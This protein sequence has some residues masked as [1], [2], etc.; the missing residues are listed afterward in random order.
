MD[1]LQF[2]FTKDGCCQKALFVL[3]SVVD[4]FTTNDSNVYLAALDISRAYDFINHFEL[5]RQ[6]IRIWV[7]KSIIVLLM[8]WYGKITGC[9]KW[10]GMISDKFVSL[11]GVRQGS[12][13]S[14]WLYNVLM[15]VL[16]Q[17]LR[18][19][20]YGCMLADLWV[21]CICYA[22]DVLLLSVFT[23]KLQAMLDVCSEFNNDVSLLF[24]AV[25]SNL[26]AYGVSAD[27]VSLP[28]VFL[29]GELVSWKDELLYLG[30]CLIARRYFKCDVRGL[31]RKFCVASNQVLRQGSKLSEE[32][33]VHIINTQ[34]VPILMYGCEVWTYSYEELRKVKVFLN[35]SMRRVLNM[36]RRSSVKE[37]MLRFG[38]LQ[39]DLSVVRSKVCFGLNC[40]RS[41]REIVKA[42][43]DR[44]LIGSEFVK[45][46]KLY[47]F[48]SFS[49]G[50]IR[51]A[52]W[53]Y[54]E[55]S[56]TQ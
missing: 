22:D 35:D 33:L 36:S 24:N 46:C 6:L 20:G 30:I 40:L 12:K 16:I 32:V 26:L 7:P 38:L 17:M 37:L 39:A 13:W 11:S 41:D 31:C 44:W 5:F 42:C 18:N 1:D 19:K 53:H 9:I 2:G 27:F 23:V 48:K 8:D 10:E 14:P 25:K 51:G 3:R 43:E 49:C 45:Y 34:C 29:H 28:E 52:I 50:K 21:G 4:Y 15:K 54:A 55:G 47:D 56:V